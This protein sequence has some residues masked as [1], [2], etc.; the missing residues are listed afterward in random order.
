MVYFNTMLL[1]VAIYALENC[2]YTLLNISKYMISVLGQVN[3]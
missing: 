3:C 2:I 1:V